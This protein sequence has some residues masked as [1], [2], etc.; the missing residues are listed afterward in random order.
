MKVEII[1]DNGTFIAQATDSDNKVDAYSDTEDEA[2]DKLVNKLKEEESFKFIEGEDKI[3]ISRNSDGKVFSIQ[4][5]RRDLLGWTTRPE[6]VIPEPT[7]EE[8]ERNNL[9]KQV[10]KECNYRQADTRDI[11]DNCVY[12]RETYRCEE[13]KWQCMKPENELMVVNE[14]GLCDYIVNKYNKEGNYSDIWISMGG[15]KR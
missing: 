4:R 3:S 6:P 9:I 8:I 10:R 5:L 14:D 1:E 13:S 11:C 15:D 7:I 12:V 2:I